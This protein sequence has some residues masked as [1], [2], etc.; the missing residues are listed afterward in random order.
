MGTDNTLHLSRWCHGFTSADVVA[1][2]HAVNLFVIFLPKEVGQ[3]VL[4]LAGRPTDKEEWERLLE[5]DIVQLMLD[6]R[7]LV[8]DPAQDDGLLAHMKANLKSE[9]TLELLYLLVTDNCNLRCNYC[10]EE[11]PEKP[12][13]YRP[14]TMTCETA[15]LA[16]ETFARLQA[17][18]SNPSK[19][20]IVHL[21]GGEP[22]LNPEVVEY[23]VLYT[24]QL[25]G[26]GDLPPNT[27]ITIVTNGTLM[28]DAQADFL[29]LHHVTVGLSLDGP[30][31]INNL[32]RLGKRSG[33]DV[34]AA[35]TE[36]YDRLIKR[37]AKVGLSVTLTPESVHR[38]DEVLAY[39]ADRMPEADGF[40]FN[41]LHFTRGVALPGD[42]YEKAVECQLKAFEA[43][44]RKGVYE[45]RLMRKAKAFINRKPMYADCGVIGN[46]L[47][48]APDGSVGVCQDFVKPKTYFN[49]SVYDPYFD[50][51]ASGLFEGWVDRSPF[52]MAECQA[53][54]ALGLCGG[55]CPASAEV[56]H[57]DRW[58][59][60]DRICHHSRTVLQWL[61]WDTYA[62]IV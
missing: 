10:F 62:K 50:H 5:P 34:S 55:G 7:L 21:Y 1:L 49:G 18:Y 46:Q 38:F 35:V 53:C 47:V 42:Y 27:E 51:V 32:H 20:K 9:I 26:R 23:A 4:G 40:S 52:N 54:P 48:I 6:E 60:D 58:H 45:E 14:G 33:L 2:Y 56:K 16:L 12:C 57:G 43:F 44:R 61:I 39:F 13:D 15:R 3:E 24:E 41:L 19:T 37:R 17:R 28:T 59:V 30:G 25:K 36:T 22:M 8:S 31:T 11:T 29:A